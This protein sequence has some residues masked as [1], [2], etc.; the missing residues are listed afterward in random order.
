MQLQTED[1]FSVFSWANVGTHVC[2]ENGEK[3]VRHHTNLEQSAIDFS[4]MAA[5]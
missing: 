4:N 5:A 2:I 3:Q 1:Q